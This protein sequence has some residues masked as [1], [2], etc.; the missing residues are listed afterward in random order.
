[1]KL[2]DRKGQAMVEL[3]LMLPVLLLIIFG[4]TEFG[5]ALYIENTLTN[6]AREGAR[7]ASISSSNPLNVEQ[8]QS[9]IKEYIPFDQTGIV[10][11][12]TPTTLLQHGIETITVVVNLPFQSTVPL[13]DQLQDIT[14]KGQAS[15]LYE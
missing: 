5:R 6:A 3:A 11:E 1:M 15:M 13:I 9:H 14:L 7:M 4:I 12:I 8:L 10:I 2:N